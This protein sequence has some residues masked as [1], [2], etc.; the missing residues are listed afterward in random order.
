MVTLQRGLLLLFDPNKV[1]E[2]KSANLE[3]IVTELAKR[4]KEDER[5]NELH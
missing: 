2:T 5:E 4:E 1:I 3:Q